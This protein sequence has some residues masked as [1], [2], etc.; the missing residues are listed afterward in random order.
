MILET[1]AKELK[2]HLWQVKNVIELLENNSTIPFI[3]RYR[4]ERSGNLDEVQIAQICD[5]YAYLEELEERKIY[6]LK[7]IEEQGK[8]TTELKEKISN[9]LLKQEIEDLFLPF[10]P[11]KRTKA[12]IA[13]EKGLEPLADKIFAQNFRESLEN[14]AKPFVVGEIQTIQEALEGASFILA[15]K[16][17]ENAEV[18]SYLRE[19]IYR[20]GKIS[21]KVKKD[22]ANEKTKFELYYDFY[23]SLFDL[24][25]HRVLA[26]FRGEEE[27]VLKV[28]IETETERLL[29]FLDR[30]FILQNSPCVKFLQETIS[31]AFQ[32]L[33]FPSVESEIRTILKE[34]AD[35][36]SIKVF[37][38]NLKNVLLASPGGEHWTIGIDPGFR[39]GSKV[40]VIDETGKFVKSVLIFV[41]FQQLSKIREAKIVLNDLFTRFEKIRFV[42]IGNGTASREVEKFVDDFLKEFYLENEVKKLV[43]SEAGASVY[44]ASEIARDEFPELDV[45]ERGAVS[46]ARRFQDPLAELVKIDPKAIGI[47]QYQH[48]V[49]QTKLKKALEQTVE[50]CVNFVGVD[51][52]T[53]SE[54]LLAAVSG[55]G[56][57]I[58][59]NIVAFRN[60]NGR[61]SSRN[62]L[63]KVPK[64]GNKSFEQC[65]GFLR[66]R[67]GKNPLDLTGVHP[68]S[69][70]V[71]EKILQKTGL[72][73]GEI[74]GNE[75]KLKTLHAEDFVT[76]DFGILTVTDILKE[77]AKP[78]RDPRKE[79]QTVRFSEEVTEIS[80]LNEGMILEGVVTN[81]TNFG[82]FVDIGVHQDGLVHVSEL[83]NKF[84]K[85]PHEIVKTGQL[86][87]VKV[88]SVEEE[89]KRIQLS[90]KQV[91]N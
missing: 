3:A 58:A 86:V 79:F 70:E 62:E 28:K 32:R 26:I 2:L 10:K 31:D 21:A 69:Y 16:F 27:G 25:A 12:T 85:N 47:G 35:E 74:L 45:T 73:L 77:L 34:K 71:V 75:E 83:A 36:E 55:I 89:R 5:R 78:G 29:E 65:A 63:L 68:E 46:I 7:T 91:E 13:K 43:V 82:A 41:S 72:Q 30:K 37:V 20:Y 59:K 23:D 52:N 38:E 60:E 4:K 67:N 40:V 87:K 50:S 33:L 1:I 42:A 84:V 61:F 18:K 39:T 90:M 9:S 51:L 57:G 80:D 54:P 8:L 48:D 17:S 24:P 6:V 44:S 88:I 81:I 19:K 14:I 49:N 22:F 64:L 11:K 53:A 76:E 66:I 56:K 15:E